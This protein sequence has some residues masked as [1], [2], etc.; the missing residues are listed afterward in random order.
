MQTSFSAGAAYGTRTDS[1][2]SPDQFALLQTV[3]L[4]W[5]FDTKKL[6]GEYQHPAVIARGQ[7]SITGKI[8]WAR[9]FGSIY[10]DLFFGET[11][12]TANILLSEDE[13]GTIPGTS[14]FT[15]TVANSTLWTEDLGVYV[16]S[17]GTRLTKSGSVTSTTYTAASGVY[18]FH[19]SLAGAAV[20]I[21]YLYTASSGKKIT[22]NNHLMGITPT[23]KLALYNPGRTQTGT[24][25]R[26]LNLNMCTANKLSIPDRIGEFEITELD[27]EAFADASDVVG[28]WSTR[29]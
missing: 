12:T 24:A 1:T 28:Y 6:Y 3:S 18:T 22:I 23:F 4:D 13:A 20:K 19:S 27:F 16:V 9:V 15:V 17:S 5:S 25:S 21:S 2:T 7:A 29:E 8:G 14:A 11:P 10:A 26:V